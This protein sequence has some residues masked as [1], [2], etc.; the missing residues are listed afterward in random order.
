MQSDHVKSAKQI[1]GYLKL[2]RAHYAAPS[3]YSESPCLILRRL[4][5][6][7]M[8]ASTLLI[9]HEL[10]ASLTPYNGEAL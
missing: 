7:E 1:A 2:T 10:T 6:R 9:A 4:L 3:G 8:D 5:A